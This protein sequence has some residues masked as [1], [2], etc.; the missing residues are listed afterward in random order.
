VPVMAMTLS[1]MKLMQIS[2]FD[3]C[4]NAQGTERVPMGLPAVVRDLF[5]TQ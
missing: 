3:R 4:R 2:L 1:F 5:A